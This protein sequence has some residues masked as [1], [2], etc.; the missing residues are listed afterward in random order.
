MPE[1]IRAGNLV[2][3]YDSFTAVDGIDFSVSK[4]ECFGF[5]GPNGAGK[6]TTVRMISC[7]SPV[8]EGEL[9]VDDLD[10]G[11]EPRRIK[12][13]LG[14][15][16]QEDNLDPDL[17]VRQNLA[18]YARYFDMPKELANQRI[19]ESLALFQL[20]EKQREPIWALS[21]GLKRRLT[22]A[23]G[24]IN[25]PKI[26]V[27]DEPTTGLDPQARHLV[28]QKLRYLKEQGVTMLLCTHYMEEAAHLCDRLVIMHQGRILVEGS[29]AVLVEEHA[30]REVAEVHVSAPQR[31][32]VLAEMASRPGL[33]VEE[34]EDVLYIY[35]RTPDGRAQMADLI[36]D[37]ESVAYHQANLEDVFLRLTGR[38]LIE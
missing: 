31:E 22:I 33:T 2:K 11:R 16:P 36:L 17:S 15:V 12:S 3:R 34:V 27:L 6:T 1:I 21:T 29:P 38:G 9:A 37:A 30:G 24:L 14:V 7:V 23:R 19:D 13:I 10:V 35:A 5:L 32:R 8:T 20:E 26:L 18:V 28:W 4:G 25:Q